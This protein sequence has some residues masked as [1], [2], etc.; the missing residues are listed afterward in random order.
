MKVRILAFSAGISTLANG[1]LAIYAVFTLAIFN[2]YILEEPDATIILLKIS[3]PIAAFSIAAYLVRTNRYGW[4]LLVGIL[5][6]S[7][8]AAAVTLH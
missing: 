3:A 6:L 5:H 1:I 4:S 2:L 7:Y 8:F